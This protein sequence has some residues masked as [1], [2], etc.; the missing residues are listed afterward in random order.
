MSMPAIGSDKCTHCGW[1]LKTE[2]IIFQGQPYHKECYEKHIQL[3]CNHCGDPIEGKY[4]I[5]EGGNYHPSC[6][7]ENILD[8]CD[9]CTQ[10]LSGEYY[11]DYWGNSFHVKHW[12]ELPECSTC[13]RL[14]SDELT[15]GGFQHKD[16]RHICSICDQTSVT[17]DY[18]VNSALKYTLRLLA[19]NHIPDLPQDIAITLVD[20][21]ELKR[22]SNIF[23]DSMRG[24]T[25]HNMSLR[26]GIVESRSSHIYILHNLPET[27]FRAVLAHELLHVYLF[28]QDLD[29]RSDIREGFCNLGS[30][31]VYKDVQTEFS[32]FQLVNMM[33]STDPDYGVGY[34][35]MSTLL[36]NKGWLLLLRDLKKFK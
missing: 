24:F 33:K 10:P 8:R 3:R 17:A 9:I 2:Y 1:E 25:D 13:G 20:Q 16:G 30:E 4:N 23:N 22:I 11:S 34:R 12:N 35:K 6:F 36:E 29:L 21:K 32:R 18:Q 15:S 14:V 26:N 31:M 7:H 27:M 28:E 19:S 5:S